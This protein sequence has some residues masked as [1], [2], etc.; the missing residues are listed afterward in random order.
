MLTVEDNRTLTRVGKGTP[1]GE[2]MRRYWHPIAAAQELEER[3]TKPVR[4]L[5]EDLVLYKDRS[6]SYGLIDRFCPHRKVDLSYG[7]PEENG[8]RCMYHGWMYD[9]TGQCIEQPF[10][11]TVHPSGHFKDKV[12]VTAYPVEGLGGLLFA[13]MG[14]QPVPLLPRWDLFVT[15]H[16]WRDIGFTVIPCNWL[17]C[18]EN[19]ADPVHAEWLHGV[20]G[21]YLAQKSGDE[22]P[23]WRKAMM[24]PHQ[25]IAFTEF[26]HGVFKRR[27]VEGTGEQD[28]I[29]RIGH[30]WVFPNILRSTTGTTSTE[31]Q[32]RVPI[33][34]ENTLHVVYTR[35]QFPPETEVPDQVVVP[36]Y[37]IPLYID[38]ELNLEVPLPQDFMAWVTQGPVVDRT[39]EK[40]GE[41][42]VGVIQ[43]RRMLFD[44]IKTVEDGGDPMNV[45][46]DPEAN[47]CILMD[48]ERVYYTPDR[49]EARMIYHGHQRYNPG[50]DQ[51]VAMF[52]G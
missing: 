33:D 17:Q 13:Y 1:M 12:K 48:Q 6:G 5:G 16:A 43:L 24:R 32:I 38:G 10:E 36:Y 35:Y 29:W 49:N 25:R 26:A 9:E 45:F 41:S 37:E 3:P 28:D 18:Q 46:R 51:I 11:D 22:V 31:F 2:L 40:L 30:P 23:S 42:D 19:S 21:W 52:P 50:I 34:D 47:R 7:I 14:P 4:L 27:I 20:Y 15:D 44:A 39:L 8:L